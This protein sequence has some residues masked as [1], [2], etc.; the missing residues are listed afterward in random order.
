VAPSSTGKGR[1]TNPAGS[2]MMGAVGRPYV[3]VSYAREDIEYVQ[4]LQDYLEEREIPVW[5]DLMTEVGTRWRKRLEQR[6]ADAAAVVLVASP[7]AEASTWVENELYFA[8]KHGIPIFPII[9]E[10]DLWFGTRH[11]NAERCL[12]GSMP[13]DAFVAEVRRLV[14]AAGPR[15][16][17]GR[18]WTTPA[19]TTGVRAL[20]DR[21]GR[22]SRGTGPEAWLDADRI[23]P[24]MVERP[25][26]LHQV[27]D[28]LL[29]AD[30]PDTVA[31]TGVSGGGGL[32]K[33]V[34]AR[35]VCARAEVRQAFPGGLLWVD[36]GQQ[37]RDSELAAL[38]GELCTRLGGDDPGLVDPRVAGKSLAALLAARP[39]TLVVLDDAWFPDQVDPFLDPDSGPAR[40][41]VT[42]RVNHVIPDYARHVPLDQL[43]PAQSRTVLLAGLP[44]LPEGTVARLLAATGGW[45]LVVKS[46]NAM[47]RRAIEQGADPAGYAAWLAD[48]LHT[49]GVET[50]GLGN[51]RA[52]EKTF[53]ATMAPSLALLSPEERQRAYELSIFAED[54][55]IEIGLLAL[56][57]GATGGL[58]L[59]QTRRLAA[60]LRDLNL[61]TDFRPDL[62]ILRLHDLVRDYLASQLDA[63]TTR[64]AHAAFLDAVAAKY[65]IETTESGTRAWWTLPPSA[66][67][68]WQHLTHHLAAAGGESGPS[69][70][71][72]LLTD[73][74]WTQAKLLAGSIP[75]LDADLG[76]SRE[77]VVAAL[78]ATVRREAHLLGPIEPIH[79]HG[80]VVAARLGADP[81]L[82]GCV[83][84][85]RRS[86]PARPVRLT[87]GWP[88]PDSE[89]A[90]RRVLIGHTRWV[91][92][93]A[94]APDGTWLATTSH[95]R[96]VR[97]WDAETGAHRTFTGHT[98]HVTGIAI[99]PTG[100][101]LATTSRDGTV[102]LWD[103]ASGTHRTLTGHTGWVTAVAIAPDGTWLATT[104]T[105]R[106]VR[107][108]D[109]TTGTQ[110]SVLT[111]HTDTVTSVAIAPDGTW[112]A[113]T[114]TDRTVR[115]WNPTTGA[116]L[117]HHAGRWST[118]DGRPQPERSIR[119]RRRPVGAVP[120]RH[121][122][123]P[124]FDVAI[125]WRSPTQPGAITHP[126]RAAV[127]A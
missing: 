11:I 29:T 63:A 6:L 13:R 107:L 62:G 74:R 33:T 28:G 96:T 124:W 87:A 89:P 78:R 70:L 47:L 8:N 54:T 88:V 15:E 90:L 17:Q 93:V 42:T 16:G 79:S 97:L 101:W 58:T 116:L 67:Y 71:D 123:P 44:A 121:R 117:A 37:R 5:F 53:A 36:L 20:A 3:F 92:A 31:V 30:G 24:D 56:L 125:P 43:D 72:A 25:T 39:P 22:S 105:D 75:S 84:T 114:S 102:R 4:R 108:W 52:R 18:D 9:I 49:D 2:G 119:L 55:D 1:P 110:R 41:L 68:L 23:P 126:S 81:T 45:A 91:T 10:G 34:L 32:G 12:D 50:L 103:T 104:S 111:G 26:Q 95:D 69:E 66:D 109:P 14:L 83:E 21:P 120:V 40:F 122:N 115:I 19:G 57:W 46:A 99:A 65:H 82:A 112:L 27:L 7:R 94:I 127:V 64:R 77:P 76:R 106:T 59:A 60:E 85:F 113:T 118:R 48:A 80:D 100:T 73:L 61:A 98:D 35:M 51:Q 86:Q 38:I